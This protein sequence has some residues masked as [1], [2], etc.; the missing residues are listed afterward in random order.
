LNKTAATQAVF[1]DLDGTFA[2]TAPDLGAALN[3]VRALHKLPPLPIELTRLQASHGSAGL[4]KLGFDVTPDSAAFPALRDEFL[5]YYSANICVHTFLFDGMA[6]LIDTLEQR[7]LPWGIVTNKPHRFT[8]PL[9]QALG[10]GKRATCLVSGDTCAHPKPHPEP[11]LYAAKITKVPPQNCL[12]LG[13]DKRDID[14]GRAA[15]MKT[16]IALFGYIDTKADL[17]SWQASASINSPLELLLQL[18]P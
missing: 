14:A 11:L 2:D 16:L 10:Y 7:G 1:F 3:H 18:K 4:L 6:E 9:M 15:G 13:D 5:A 8:M 12:Y 17:N